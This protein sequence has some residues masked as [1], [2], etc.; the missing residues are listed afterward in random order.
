MIEVRCASAGLSDPIG[1]DNPWVL[2]M[3]WTGLAWDTLENL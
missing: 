2:A 1:Q 3:D